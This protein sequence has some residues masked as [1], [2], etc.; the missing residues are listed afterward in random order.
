V[1]RPFAGLPGEADWVAMREI[2]PAATVPLTLA[3]S[4]AGRS[5]TLSTVLPLAWPAM[6]RNDGEVFVG[7]QVHSGSGDVSRDIAAAL[8]RALE[9]DAGTPIAPQG[10][11]GPGPR[12]QDVLDLEAP[13]V[14]EVRDGFD[15]WVE[16]MDTGDAE[17][18]ASMDRANAAVMPTERLE[19]V[20]A[21]YTARLPDKSHLR[22]VLPDPEE[23]LLDAMARLRVAGG[24]GL[25]EDTRYVGAFRAHGLVVPVWDL[26]AETY[27]ASLEEAAAAWRTR[28]D[29]ALALDGPLTGEERRAR[30]GL[31]SRQLTLR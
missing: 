14:V 3:E 2:V 30:N 21:A 11:P 9:A 29:E 31:V 1:E 23:A 17:T 18:R 4:W 12:L 22:W 24:L 16:G 19:S 5:A 8:I 13:F 28:L 26:P 20:T 6:V 25:G 15:F 27:A 7:L 10:L